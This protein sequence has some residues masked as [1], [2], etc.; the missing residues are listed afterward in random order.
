MPKAIDLTGKRFGKLIVLS[1]DLPYT[2][3]KGYKVKKWLCQCDCGNKISVLRTGLAAKT[4]SCGCAKAEFISA[5]NKTHGMSNT[6]TYNAWQSMKERCTNPNH[7]SYYNYKNVEI[8]KSWLESFDNFYN[9]M[10]RCPKGL[11]LDRIDNSK[12]YSKSNCRWTD[13]KT[14]N[15][16]KRHTTSKKLTWQDVC[17]I[18]KSNL[19]NKDLAE[20]YNI[21]STYVRQIKNYERCKQEF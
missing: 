9:D 18:R 15:N 8:C 11:T 16:N 5:K 3:P 1:E 17:N 19:N 4:K 20:L 14:Q 2:S 13:Y 6:K 10:G 12:G 7:D 21:S